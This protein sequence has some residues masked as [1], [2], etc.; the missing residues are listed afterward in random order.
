MNYKKVFIDA[1]IF[2][3]LFDTDRPLRK[4]SIEA[5]Q[6]LLEENTELYPSFAILLQQFIMFLERNLEDKL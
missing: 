3:D 2:I 1:N 5:I 4:Y 6:K